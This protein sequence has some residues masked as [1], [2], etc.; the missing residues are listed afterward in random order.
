[1]RRGPGKPSR[2]PF[3]SNNAAV[4]ASNFWPNASSIS[5]RDTVFPANSW[6]RIAR[7]SGGIFE[8]LPRNFTIIE[9][10]DVPYTP[11]S[12]ESLIITDF[13][14]PS[15]SAFAAFALAFAALTAA[16]L[17]TPLLAF[18]EA[19]SCCAAYHFPYSPSSFWRCAASWFR[20]WI[21]FLIRLK[22]IVKRYVR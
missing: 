15:T 16:V 19:N 3:G 5:F 14:Y 12:P 20:F 11:F 7:R 17:P 4:A 2:L 10:F 18:A 13:T 1:M 8:S 9:P 21:N 6:W 22:A